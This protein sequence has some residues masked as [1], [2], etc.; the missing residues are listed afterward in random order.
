MSQTSYLL[1]SG[2]AGYIGSHTA[3]SALDK[4]YKVIIIDDLSSGIITNLPPQALFIKGDIGDQALLAQVFSQY[5]IKAVLHF[6]GSVIVSES[7]TDPLKYYENNLSKSI[8]L[9][10]ACS[11]YGVKQFIFSSTAA[12]YGA[13][14]TSRV[15]ENS[16]TQPINPYGHS[17]LIVEQIIK[18][19]AASSPM[20]YAI[21]RY[22]NV[23]GADPQGRTG[24]STRN[25]T[26]LIKVACEVAIGKRPQLT[27]FGDNYHTEDGTCI[28][29]Y[30]HVTDLAEA[31]LAALDYLTKTNQSTVLNCGI[32]RGF[33]VKQ[34]INTLEKLVNRPVD[35]VIGP[36]RAG[37]SPALVANA[38]LIKQ[39]TDWQ[40]NFTDLAVIIKTALDWEKKTIHNW[41]IKG[42]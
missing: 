2:G 41:K 12:V 8:K 3:Y 10:K 1:I 40:P 13:P 42:S 9:I 22:F 4:G 18:D 33:S 20:Q 39:I 21:L 36:P 26:H 24:Q 6:A 19:V 29:D 27:I 23:A 17:K 15:T 11:R 7:I 30:I 31:H 25:A 32:G 34:V 37:D 16:S 14:A 5:P 35:T 28:R 38:E